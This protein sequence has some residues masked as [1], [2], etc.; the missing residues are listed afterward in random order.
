[1]EVFQLA[2][3]RKA[4]LNGAT[5]RRVHPFALDQLSR[6]CDSDIFRLRT[7]NASFGNT[8]SSLPF[9][10]CAG[11]VDS[12]IRC[13][14]SVELNAHFF[15]RGRSESLKCCRLAT[16]PAASPQAPGSRRLQDTDSHEQIALETPVRLTRARLERPLHLGKSQNSFSFF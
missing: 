15:Y 4:R 14:V 12:K 10:L 9:I 3:E 16:M 13:I 11:S 8:R 1:M 7:A 2:Q 6:G 5:V